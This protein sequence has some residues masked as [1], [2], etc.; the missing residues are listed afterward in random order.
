MK[1]RLAPLLLALALCA[2]LAAT[3]L[4][5][6]GPVP[7]PYFTI[8]TQTEG[9]F[10]VRMDRSADGE[11]WS[12]DAPGQTIT[13]SGTGIQYLELC[14]AAAPVNLVLADGTTGTLTGGNALLTVPRAGLTIW[15]SAR[16]TGGGPPV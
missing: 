8:S 1:Q 14:R 12:F 3:A 13:L 16:S 15:W 9:R 7:G 6:G 11:G 10:V 5:G 2:G 4:A